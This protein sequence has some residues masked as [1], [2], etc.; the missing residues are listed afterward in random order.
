LIAET[1]GDG[2]NYS[3]NKIKAAL[4]VMKDMISSFRIIE[5]LN[6]NSNGEYIILV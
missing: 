4:K 5:K 3:K 2:G 1:I 6:N